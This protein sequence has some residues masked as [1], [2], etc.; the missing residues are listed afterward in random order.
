MI[1][2]IAKTTGKTAL[3]MTLTASAAPPELGSIFMQKARPCLSEAKV[4]QRV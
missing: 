1:I 3:C 2:G 4:L